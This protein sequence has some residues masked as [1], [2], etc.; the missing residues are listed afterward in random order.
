MS[1]AR[2]LIAALAAVPMAV[3]AVAVSHAA[4]SATAALNPKDLVLRPSEVPTGFAPDR[5]NSRYWSNAALVR[6]RP[7]LAQLLQRTGRVNG[8][9]YT[10]R[11]EVGPRIRYV[12]SG[13]ETHTSIAGAQLYLRW[14]D[15]EQR[16]NN[17]T[18][19]RKG[20]EPYARLRV[21][22]GEQGWMY[23]EGPPRDY[24]L[25]AWQQGRVVASLHTWGVGVQSTLALA[26]TQQERINNAK[27]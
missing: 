8:Y 4:T 25:I 16:K 11:R 18:R 13:A 10:Y 14:I 3:F 24:V 22:I 27:R 7:D 2:Q 9:R 17:R 15:Q 6:D 12:S 5:K 1:R 23:V 21:R 26:R 19:E 20:Q